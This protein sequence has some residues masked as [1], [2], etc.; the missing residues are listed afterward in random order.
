VDIV[1]LVGLI[2]LSVRVGGLITEL[3]PDGVTLDDGTGAGRIVLRGAAAELLPLLEPGDAVNV[4]GRVVAL[5]DGPAVLV[6]DEGGIVVAGDP[7]AP[8]LTSTD[9]ISATVPADAAPAATQA[10]LSSGSWLGAGAVGFATLSL[11]SAASLVLAFLRRRQARRRLATRVAARL[12][13]FDQPTRP[14]S[15][16]RS[17]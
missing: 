17:G 15:S 11:L 10:G 14:S 12:T 4:T 6:D 1:D 13:A 5:G 8:D 16:P 7:Q 2:G 9:G 3:R